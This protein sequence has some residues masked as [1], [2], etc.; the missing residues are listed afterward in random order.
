M[1]LRAP[2][3]R[4]GRWMAAGVAL[5]AI[6]A[7]C[8]G[9]ANDTVVSDSPAVTSPSDIPHPETT[10]PT[11][12]PPLPTGSATTDPGTDPFAGSP[13][14]D[15]VE[16]TDDSDGRRLRI[17][18]TD[19]G[20]ADEFP[21]AVDRA[22]S[23]VVTDSPAADTPGMYDQFTCH[24]IWA[25]MVAPNKPSWNLEPWRPAVGYPATVQAMCN[26]GGPDPAGS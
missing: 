6:P 4:C 20:R 8:A 21:P 5:C 14:I 23:E 24:W 22:W 1:R 18:P 25:R 19:A 13:L 26:P 2:R 17:Y 16:W 3:S 9:C 7:V 10:T 15:H 12:Q 11:P